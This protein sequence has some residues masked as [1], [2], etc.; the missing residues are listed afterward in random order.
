VLVEHWTD[1]DVLEVAGVFGSWVVQ[2]SLALR[3]V[4]LWK[5]SQRLWSRKTTTRARLTKAGT[6]LPTQQ[7]LGHDVE[8]KGIL[9]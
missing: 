2:G 3:A 5:G 8:G 6:V 4:V 7:F 9:G 1:L